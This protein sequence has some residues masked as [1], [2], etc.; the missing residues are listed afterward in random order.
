MNF[1]LKVKLSASSQ[2]PEH[3]FILFWSLLHSTRQ[4]IR[5]LFAK[6]HIYCTFHAKI[7]LNTF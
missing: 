5:L 7:F 6:T 4:I 3:S 1:Q 2:A